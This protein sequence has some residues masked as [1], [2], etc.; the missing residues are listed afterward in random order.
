MNILNVEYILYEDSF[1]AN[2]RQARIMIAEQNSCI[3]YLNK[4]GLS[5]LIQEVTG[6][7][8]LK[9]NSKMVQIG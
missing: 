2:D 5:N 1:N 7:V 6:L 8:V 3:N 9:N 4:V